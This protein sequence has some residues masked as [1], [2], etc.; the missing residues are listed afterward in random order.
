MSSTKFMYPR[1]FLRKD[2]QDHS[3]QQPKTSNFVSNTF[4]MLFA[5]NLELFQVVPLINDYIN[6]L[7]LNSL[8]Q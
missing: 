1:V 8:Q 6:L 7:D 3:Y 5:D 4:I 2:M